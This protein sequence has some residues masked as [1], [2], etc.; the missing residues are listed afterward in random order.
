VP[1]LPV[2]AADDTFGS[3]WPTLARE[4]GLELL[5]VTAASEL[6]AAPDL[7]PP[8]LVVPGRETEAE[9]ELRALDAAGLPGAV[10]VGSVTDHRFAIGVLRAG[11]S[12]YVA[13]PRDLAI[14]ESIVQAN[15]KRI[16]ARAGKQRLLERERL[17][18]D[19]SQIVGRSRAL[20][21]ALDRAASVIPH[22]Q[23]GVLIT[24]ETGTGKELVARAIH[25]NG[26]RAGAPFVEINCAA[27]PSHLLESEMFGFERGAFTDARAAKPGLLEAADGGTLFL[28]EIGHLPLELQGKLLR[29][30]E[31]KRGRRLGS[32]RDYD[33]D[34]RIVAAT[35]VDLG[36]A[37]SRR[38]FREDLYYRLAIIPIHLPPLRERGDD[39]ILLAKHFLRK[40]GARYNLAPPPLDEHLRHALLAHDWPGNVR[41]LRNSLERALLL[42]GGRLEREDL[43][44]APPAAA[45]DRGRSL[46]FPAPL[47]RI[48]REAA[49]AM[50]E[51]VDGNKSAAASALGISRS[52][53][54][55]LLE[56]VGEDP[57]ARAPLPEQRGGASG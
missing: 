9:T 13:L 8:L 38:V 54:Y 17:E 56:G 44:M 18:Y 1:R 51:R 30:I 36:L 29:A 35:N 27:I 45:T 37:V 3:H 26:R 7:L 53:L 40:L 2:I 21:S 32:L 14:L 22:E 33:V 10:V 25:A 24:G 55:R 43:F 28:D 16:Q 39:V 11:A 23:A 41:E 50:L 42:G 12:D 46:P 19:F 15:T 47:A 31:E 4:H 49:R 6:R 20:R 5:R 52:R 57:A 48:E 34:V